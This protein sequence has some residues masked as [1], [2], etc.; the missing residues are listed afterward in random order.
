MIDAAEATKNMPKFSRAWH[1]EHSRVAIHNA[2]IMLESNDPAESAKGQRTMAGAYW[3]GLTVGNPTTEIDNIL[4]AVSW[5]D[6]E[7]VVPVMRVGK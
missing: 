4:W 3:K 1:T 7:S 6:G 2:L 5:V